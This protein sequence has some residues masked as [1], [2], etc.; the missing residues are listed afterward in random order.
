MTITLINQVPES[1]TSS[2]E[3]RLLQ[4]VRHVSM[5]ARVGLPA[6][7]EA[8]IPTQGSGY[9][10]VAVTQMDDL[11]LTSN[12]VS[13][14]GDSQV[15]VA[16]VA[17]ENGYYDFRLVAQSGT[18][19]SVIMCENSCRT[20][21]QLTIRQ[22]GT[23]LTAVTVVDAHQQT[24]VSTAQQWQCYAIVNG[25]TTG[26]ATFKGSTARV[27]LRAGS[28]DQYSLEVERV[29]PPGTSLAPLASEPADGNEVIRVLRMATGVR[30]SCAA[31]IRNLLCRS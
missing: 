17:A 6:G 9:T 22:T 30:S 13:F 10:A 5:V 29:E 11:T 14:S 26:T 16:Q 19:L 28:D 12:E 1:I 18:D 25:I 7:G 31:S 24:L 20:P 15:L 21:V 3:F 4:G 23:P 8:V 2:A 27:T